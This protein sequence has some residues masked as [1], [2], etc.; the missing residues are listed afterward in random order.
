MAKGWRPVPPW[1]FVTRNGTPINQRFVEK[2]FRRICEKA[3]LPD[4]LTPRSM[5]HTFA[6]LHIGQG[7]SAKCLQPQMG[8]SSINLTLDTYAMWS[9]LEDHA[10]ADALGALVAPRWQRGGSEGGL[11]ALQPQG[12]AGKYPIFLLR[13]H[14][15]VG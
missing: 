15:S 10:A 6:C 11:T 8:Y 2:D 4:H 5:R 13:A 1:A 12:W 14:S 3:K 9:N 7:W